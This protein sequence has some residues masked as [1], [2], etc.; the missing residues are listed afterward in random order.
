MNCGAGMCFWG[1]WSEGDMFSYE[2]GQHEK[3]NYKNS[4][5]KMEV[6]YE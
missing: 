6:S 4:Y 2:Q 1:V 5:I 3:R